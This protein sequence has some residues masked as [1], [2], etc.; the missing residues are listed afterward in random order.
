MEVRE[1]WGNSRTVVFGDS[2][3]AAWASDATKTGRGVSDSHGY[4]RI[5]WDLG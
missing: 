5:R 4:M 1:A 2:Q 3:D